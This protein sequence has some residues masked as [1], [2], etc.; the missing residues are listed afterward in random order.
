[1]RDGIEAVGE[2]A[3]GVVMGEAGFGSGD[4][5]LDTRATS[6]RRAR[7]GAARLGQRRRSAGMAV[8]ARAVCGFGIVRFPNVVRDTWS[9]ILYRTIADP[10]SGLISAA[11]RPSSG[12]VAT[13]SIRP[14]NTG[15][16]VVA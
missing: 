7:D 15:R 13:A 6:A 1:M 3:L 4:Q 5:R 14:P 10:P 11:P 16:R 2:P 9:S 12:S 8:V